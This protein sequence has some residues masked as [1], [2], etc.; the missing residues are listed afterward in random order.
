MD[1]RILS[2]IPE[3]ALARFSGDVPES[4]LAFFSGHEDESLKRRRG[5]SHMVDFNARSWGAL[6]RSWR[7]FWFIFS[8]SLLTSI[9]HQLS[10]DFGRVWGGLWEA[11]KRNSRL[12]IYY[13]RRPYRC[14]E[15]RTSWVGAFAGFH[16]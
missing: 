9:F 14:W 3:T 12:G 16:C 13:R 6:G 7:S 11:R 15:P 1:G 5:T 4:A 8:A 10:L 2:D